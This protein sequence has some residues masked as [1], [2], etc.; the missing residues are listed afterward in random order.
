MPIGEEARGKPDQ[1]W[2]LWKRENILPLP[3][4]ELQ[5]SGRSACRLVTLFIEPDRIYVVAI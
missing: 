1:V 4:T 5:M 3:R 2:T